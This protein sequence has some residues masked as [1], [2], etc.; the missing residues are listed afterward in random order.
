MA[1][2]DEKYCPGDSIINVKRK[3]GA[4]G[5]MVL[6]ANGSDLMVLCVATCEHARVTSRRNERLPQY[7]PHNLQDSYHPCHSISMSIPYHD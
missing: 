7:S 1:R 3:V 5:L 6:I 2:L 4:S